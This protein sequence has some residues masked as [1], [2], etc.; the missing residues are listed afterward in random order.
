MLTDKYTKIYRRAEYAVANHIH[1]VGTY[2]HALSYL[3]ALRRRNIPRL[4]A[5]PLAV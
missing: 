2:R 1:I 4:Y 5:K 3:V